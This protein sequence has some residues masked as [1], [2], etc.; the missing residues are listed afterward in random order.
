MQTEGRPPC[1][2]QPVAR[3]PMGRALPR[4]SRKGVGKF[5]FLLIHADPD[6][7]VPKA[8]SE[9]DQIEQVLEADLG[10]RIEVDRL[11]RRGHSPRRLRR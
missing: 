1:T 9:I 7:T 4:R 5:Q 2:R 11:G 10:N 6:G 8:G 3:M